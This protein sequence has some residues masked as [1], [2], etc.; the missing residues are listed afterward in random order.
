MFY[1]DCIEKRPEKNME[2]RKQFACIKLDYHMNKKYWNTVE[3][4][5][6][7]P[8]GMIKIRIDE[9]YNLVGMK[10]PRKVQ[11]EIKNL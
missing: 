5:G 8:D 10:L 2:L 9:S 1:A 3:M 11:Q 6:S 4:D 7:L